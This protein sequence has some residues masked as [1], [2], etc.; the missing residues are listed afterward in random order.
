MERVC[1]TKY[2]IK[3]KEINELKCVIAKQNKHMSMK[4]PAW[5]WA[6]LAGWAGSGCL[7][8]ALASWAGLV[9]LG[10]LGWARLAGLAWLGSLGSARLAEPGLGLG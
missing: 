6:G 10:S 3:Q 9:W 7:G 4:C 2:A 5:T 1:V 8:S